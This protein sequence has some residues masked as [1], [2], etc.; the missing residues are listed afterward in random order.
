[1]RNF[2]FSEMVQNTVLYTIIYV[3]FSICII[4][5]PIEF[6]SAGFTIP[7][8]FSSLLG[9]EKFDFITYQLRRTVLTMFIHLCLPFFYFVFLA[10]VQDE[11]IFVV[12][13]TEMIHV[14]AHCSLLLVL[15]SA[16]YFCIRYA[17]SWES[18]ETIKCLKRFDSNWTAVADRINTEYRSIDNF[19]VS[20]SGI[21]KVVMTNSWILNVTNYS[22][23]CA[24]VSDVTLEAVRADEHPISHHEQSG[25][26]AQFVDIE[27]RSMSN[28]IK[29]FIIRIR[30]E[31]FRDMRDKLNKPIG[32]AREVV[33]R[34]SLSDR[35]VEA[36]LEQISTNPTFS[37]PDPEN[38]EACLGCATERASVKLSKNCVHVDVDE[39][40]ER[41][42]PCSQCF[43]RPMWCETCMAR[44]FAAKQD[45]NHPE[46]WMPGKAN[47]PTCR[48]V[49]CVLDVC[50]LQPSS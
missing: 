11:P 13:P 24:H 7:S 17:H 49:F 36:F 26:P 8:I 5:P 23:L 44:I 37:Y 28:K 43:C 15:L 22:L 6:I 9:D 48:A 34:Q 3:L 16:A 33:L 18:H 4:F 2:H 25:G 19:N 29:P 47:C 42:P 14:L 20:L 1:M 21:K 27:V 40:G 39:D 32:V 10:F 46:R 45:K 30:A 50:L 41:R 12:H 38:L 31:S 35:F